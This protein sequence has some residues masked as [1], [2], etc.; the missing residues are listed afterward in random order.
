MINNERR[1]S[2]DR[3]RRTSGGRAPAKRDPSA[4]RRS[5]SLTAR[6]KRLP[7]GKHSLAASRV[8][9]QTLLS[10]LK[11]SCRPSYPVIL[12]DLIS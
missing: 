2:G 10:A 11:R 1:A 9:N 3:A 7:H 8:K 4:R 12:I 5:C 6:F